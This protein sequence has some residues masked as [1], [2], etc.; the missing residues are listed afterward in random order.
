MYVVLVRSAASAGGFFVHDHAKPEE[1]LYKGGRLSYY[2][3]PNCSDG[4]SVVSKPE[5]TRTK[6][7]THLNFQMLKTAYTFY[8]FL[9][10]VT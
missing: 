4:K 7:I 10:K 9:Q 5:Y 3:Q 1:Y 2:L 6:L 8:T